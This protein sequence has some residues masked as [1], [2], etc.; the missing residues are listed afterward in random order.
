[1]FLLCAALSC[2]STPALAWIEQVVV[3]HET[4]LDLE[5]S[6]FLEVRHHLVLALRGGPLKSL[7]IEGIGDDIE[8]LA[9]AK[10]TRV[11]SANAAGLPLRLAQTEG[12]ALRLEVLGGDGLRG[13]TYRFDFAYRLDAAKKRLL[14]PDGDRVVLTW[15]GPRLHGGVDS[16]KV[17][18]SV[19]HG[20]TPPALPDTPERG[21]R[22]V[23]LGHVLSG[24]ARDEIELLRA[25]VAVGEPAVWQVEFE[26]A[27][28]PQ[29]LAA[30]P[31]A[32]LGLAEG[33]RILPRRGPSAWQLALAS[34]VALFVGLLVLRKEAAVSVLAQ[35][36]DSRARPLVPGPGWL[37][38][39]LATVAVLGFMASAMLH[40]AGLAMGA[41]LLV[42][43]LTVH[44]P[45]VRRSSPRGPGTWVPLSSQALVRPS[46]P[47]WVRAFDSSTLPG[48]TLAAGVLLLGVGVAYVRLPHDSL[49][50]LLSL[51]LALLLSPLFLTGRLADFPR[52]P[53]EQALPWLRLLGAARLGLVRTLEL[54]GRQTD[55]GRSGGAVDEVRV[56]IV[57]EHSPSGLRALE[58]AFEEGPGSYVS[59][60]LVLRVVEDSVAH[61]RLPR[62]IVWSRGRASEEKTS[63]LHPAAPTRAQLLRLLR[64]V[65]SHLAQ[66]PSPSNRDQKAARSSGNA[67][68]A[69]NRSVPLSAAM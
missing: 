32:P 26:R 2:A 13:G 28:A 25:H 37:K 7:E 58:V 9:D 56:R 31:Q 30:D 12:G 61:E 36:T 11:T 10:V 15:V 53:A 57:L 50:A 55:L 51:S 8:L 3:G 68:S 47:L 24:S 41:G 62:A 6:G 39:V 35:R 20:G 49:Q 29:A 16:A 14:V 44:F 43:A 40:R 45:P 69:R 38:A 54:W 23:L 17:T 64:S 59:P 46:W 52:S 5:P 48:F 1:M 18:V 33:R 63:I 42:T 34:A 4:K 21:A 22:G 66:S 19:P 27:A 65:L 60:C 67:D